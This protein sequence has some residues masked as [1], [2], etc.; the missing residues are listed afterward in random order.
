MLLSFTAQMNWRKCKNAKQ[1]NTKASVGMFDTAIRKSTLKSLSSQYA[2]WHTL[3]DYLV[4]RYWIAVQIRCG[5]GKNRQQS[6]MQ[7]TSLRSN[8]LHVN[9]TASSEL[10]HL[11]SVQPTDIASQRTQNLYLAGPKNIFSHISLIKAIKFYLYLSVQSIA[12]FWV[13]RFSKYTRLGFPQWNEMG[14]CLNR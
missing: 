1:I 7:S 2:A 11:L 5:G 3:C 14:T 8:V 6:S 9:I 13:C 4:V 10:G 12:Q